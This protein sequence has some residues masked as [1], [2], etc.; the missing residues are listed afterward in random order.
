MIRH[1][2]KICLIY[3]YAQHYRLGVFQLLDQE[4]SCDFY[5]G[6][7]MNDVKKIDYNKLVHFKKE[8]INVRLLPPI[9]WQSGAVSLFFKKYDRY[10]ILGEYYCVSTWILLLLSRFSDKKTYL[11]THGWYGNESLLKKIIKKLFFNLADGV[12][13]YGN[14]AKKLM[15]TEGFN[16]AKLHVIYNSLNYEKQISVRNVLKKTDLFQKHFK[17]NNQV[18]IFIGRLTKIKRLDLLLEAHKLLLNK[19]QIFN[20]VFVG[21]GEEKEELVLMVNKLGLDEYVWFYGAT[22]DEEEIGELIYNADICVS[23]GNVG[24]TAMHS[25]VYG[26]PVITHSEF[27]NQMPE[28]ESIKEGVSGSF[29]E[30]NNVNS[31]ADAIQNWTQKNT[32]REKIRLSCFEV[33][34]SYFNP[35]FQLREISK[36]IQLDE[37]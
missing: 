18:L 30:N 12:F 10:I 16:E 1:N 28:F 35:Q 17:N 36:N 25:M 33:I 21:L 24:L 7:K 9:Y 15:I 27:K 3:N 8:L 4:L 14:Y 22:Y 34:D 2:N 13:L 11:W 19:N 23:P 26:T 5:F 20:L 6:N 31:L 37:K 29:F 32:D